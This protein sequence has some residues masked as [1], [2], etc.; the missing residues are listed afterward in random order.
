MTS[1]HLR[2][3]IRRKPT[4]F[5]NPAS[6]MSVGHFRFHKISQ[7]EPIISNQFPSDHLSF[8]TNSPHIISFFKTD[9]KPTTFCNP[10][11]EI[12]S[13]HFGFHN[14]SELESTMFNLVRS[15][16]LSFQTNS[17]HII[18]LFKENHQITSQISPVHLHFIPQI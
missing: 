2:F 9:R 18:S 15:D 11:S 7:L 14:I 8:Q 12:S 10:T 17:P 3:R 16:H 1:W 5:C 13:E 6:V 4:T